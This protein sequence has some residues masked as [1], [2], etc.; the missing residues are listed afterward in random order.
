VGGGA[1]VALL[2]VTEARGLTFDRL[3]VVGLTRD[4]FPR[5]IRPDPLLPDPLR[6]RLR[7]LLPDL[8]VKAEG[9]TR[10]ATVRAAAR[11]RDHVALTRPLAARTVAPRRPRRSSTSWHAPAAPPRFRRRRPSR[12]RASTSR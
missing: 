7:D 11:G 6:A 10:S 2:S 3:A 8:P 5:A 4:R 1:G 9:T 12:E